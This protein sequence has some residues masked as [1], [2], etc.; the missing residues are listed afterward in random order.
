MFPSLRCAGRDAV[1]WWNLLQFT[2]VS[3][4][5]L[6]GPHLS[7]FFPDT[8]GSV[9]LK[10][11]PSASPEAFVLKCSCTGPLQPTKSEPLGWDLGS[12]ILTSSEMIQVQVKVKKLSLPGPLLQASAG[13]CPPKILTLLLSPEGTPGLYCGA[14]P[15]APGPSLPSL[16]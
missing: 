1:F 4:L 8:H 15:Q 10:V 3:A 6:L 13:S 5:C 2:C 9:L 14:P 7:P 16:P 11:W 12:G